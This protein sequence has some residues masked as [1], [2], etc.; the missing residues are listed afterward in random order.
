LL[1][2]HQ[3]QLA[4]GEAVASEIVND[5]WRR[6]LGFSDLPEIS[7]TGAGRTLGLIAGAHDLTLFA[8]YSTDTVGH[9]GDLAACVTALERVDAFLAG[10]LETLPPDHHLLVCSDHGNIE[11]VGVR[12]HTRH[13][14]LG[15]VAGPDAAGLA[16]SLTSLLD[17]TPAVAGWL[18][19][20]G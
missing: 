5:G 15:L 14:A 16:S 17:V 9:G 6:H 4:R 13:P 3:E 8:H 20:R 2:R 18:G 10:L 12:G 1:V 11:D 19:I 7:A